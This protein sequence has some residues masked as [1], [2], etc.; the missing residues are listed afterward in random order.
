MK[1][2]SSSLYKAFLYKNKCYIADIKYVFGILIKS[3]T[4][5]IIQTVECASEIL[6]GLFSSDNAFVVLT[7]IL[8]TLEV[9]SIETGELKYSVYVLIHVIIQQKVGEEMFFHDHSTT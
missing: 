8:K 2:F 1:I 3:R 9:Y 5:S 6:M 4:D 7:T